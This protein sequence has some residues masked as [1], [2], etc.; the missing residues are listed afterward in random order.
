MKLFGIAYDGLELPGYAV[1]CADNA[2]RALELL[3]A[4]QASCGAKG[5]VINE[6]STSEEGVLHNNDG[7]VFE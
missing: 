2:V 4:V 7:G 3:R 6:F 1:V 5:P